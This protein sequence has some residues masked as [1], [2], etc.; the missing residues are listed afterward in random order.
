MNGTAK[1]VLIFSTLLIVSLGLGACGGAFSFNRPA[2]TPY[3]PP[4]L[5][6]SPDP[7]LLAEGAQAAGTPTQTPTPT[8]PQATATP[9]CLDNLTFLED[10]TLPDGSQVI[11]GS[12]LDKRW[13]VENSGSCNWDQ[14]YRVRLVF[15]PEQGFPLELALY[16]ARSGV[17]ATL[18]IVLTAPEGPG[19]YRVAWQAFNPQDE[20][21]GDPF[22]IDFNVE[23]P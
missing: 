8:A 3:L 4:T 2:V 6:R 13:R 7:L 12:Q 19:K 16:P 23:A 10:L 5:A 17:Q 18:R 9:A 11:A 21:F 14:D 22:F 20:P 15:G 1:A